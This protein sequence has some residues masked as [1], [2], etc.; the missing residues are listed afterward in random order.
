MQNLQV[1]R[2]FIIE[3]TFMDN[4]VKVISHPITYTHTY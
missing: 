4:A 3:H 2:I 1:I